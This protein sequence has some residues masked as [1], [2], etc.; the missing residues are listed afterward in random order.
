MTAH[1]CPDCGLERTTDGSPGCDCA[2]RAASTAGDT[3]PLPR[4]PSTDPSPHLPGGPPHGT[5][6]SGDF[7][8]GHGAPGP[9]DD[10][11]G[12]PV[13]GPAATAADPDPAQ[14]RNGLPA[15][16]GHAAAEGPAETDGPA[17]SNPGAYAEAGPDA[18]PWSPAPGAE[19]PS[20]DA[21]APGTAGLADDDPRQPEDGSGT[22]PLSL[23]PVSP[24]TSLVSMP[25]A[26]V[27]GPREEDLGLFGNFTPAEPTGPATAPAAPAGH[28]AGDPHASGLSRA[29][30][31]A[32]RREHRRR[33]AA[34][35]AAA[36]AVAAVCAGVLAVGLAGS[37]ES[38]KDRALPDE[39]PR[40]PTAVLPTGDAWTG[41]GRPSASATGPSASG[42]P[43]GSP[44]AS[45]SAGKSASGSPDADRTSGPETLDETTRPEAAPVLSRGMS[46]PEVLEMQRRLNQIG[47]SLK[48]DEDGRYTG[49][50]ARAISR[51]Q[52]MYGVE[53]DPSGVYG[54]A[55]RSSLESRT[56]G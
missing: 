35:A 15:A 39:N 56:G 25:E 34:I 43:S 41:S 44:S 28:G 42:T 49:N 29:E 50:E 13:N 52:N 10:G 33:G 31:R 9:E 23:R 51:Y 8:N 32:N 24:A 18:D 19:Q 40:V 27:S 46:G 20:G 30:H 26:P 4:V 47:R 45:P 3:A 38:E 53:G 14:P 55:T 54:P 21:P 12:F 17:H 36:V 11:T 5:P 1:L 37:G 16:P 7:Q 48:V 6:G 22:R 2:G